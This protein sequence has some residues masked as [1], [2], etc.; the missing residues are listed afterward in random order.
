M[1]LLSRRF[2]RTFDV[3]FEWPKFV[4]SKS[5][6][7]VSFLTPK[8]VTI[9]AISLL[10]LG[11]ETRVSAQAPDTSTSGLMNRG[12]GLVNSDRSEAIKA[13]LRVT[14]R[15]SGN[16]LAQRQLGYLF[17]VERKDTAALS[18]FLSAERIQSSDTIRLQ[19]AFV[20]SRLGR[21]AEAEELLA[22]LKYSSDPAIREQAD[23]Q[24]QGGA[25]AAVPSKSWPRIY[26]ETFYD[27]RWKSTFI[28]LNFQLGEYIDAGK[29][30]GV[31]GV[32]ALSTDTKSSGGA[33]P[34]IISDNSFILGAGLRINA[35]RSL[36]AEV[37]E[38]VAYHLIDPPSTSKVEN[39]FRIVAVYNDGMYAPFELHPNVRSPLAP[40]FDCYGSAGYYVRYHNSI[41][42]LQLRG[43]LRVFEV[44]KSVADAYAIGRLS[45]DTGHEFYNNIYE[46]GGGLRVT[47]NVNFGLHVV[48]EYAHGRYLNNSPSATAE[49]EKLYGPAYDSFR[50]LV[51]L[52]HIF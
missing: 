47:P 10:L 8:A 1:R 25:S 35:M 7:L 38:G 30:L 37:Q 51:I 26:L 20:L 15:D 36:F 22:H 46:F 12:F 4:I 34:T 39:D 49:R 6:L 29:R 27:T 23:A 17:L 19:I 48:G 28:N 33:V 52:D 18:H 3:A 11:I 9:I 41:G 16:L 40:F 21:K 13:F 45:M 2:H 31:Y 14:S 32:A 5:T 43:G 42:Y 24:L 44:S 50:F